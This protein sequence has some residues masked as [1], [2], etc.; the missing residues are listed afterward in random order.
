MIVGFVNESREAIIDIVVRGPTGVEKKIEAVVDTG[1]NDELTLPSS[2]IFDLE[3][4]HAVRTQ[5]SLAGGVAIE[6][7]C[8]RAIL[9]WDQRRRSVLVL[10]LEDSR[11][12]GMG[13]L[14]GHRLTLDAIQQGRVMIEPLPESDL[15]V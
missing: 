9:I 1:F 2:L 10:E 4:Q 11:L 5:A 12:V 3:L 14:N 8:F 13:L 6:A 7:N 15:P